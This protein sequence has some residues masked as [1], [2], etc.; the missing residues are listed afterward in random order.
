MMAP[1][2]RYAE[3]LDTRLLAAIHGQGR[4]TVEL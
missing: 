4:Y 2:R 3:A 1:P